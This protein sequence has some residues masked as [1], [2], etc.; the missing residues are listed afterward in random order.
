MREAGLLR[1]FVVLPEISRSMEKFLRSNGRFDS[2]FT[3]LKSQRFSEWPG[4]RALLYDVIQRRARSI[5]AAVAIFE[6][7]AHARWNARIGLQFTQYLRLNPMKESR[8]YHEALCLAS[9][10]DAMVVSKID[11]SVSFFDIVLLKMGTSVASATG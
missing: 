3:L 6:Q 5:Q 9:T 10:L 7:S 11:P 8:N 2:H 1:L 4:F